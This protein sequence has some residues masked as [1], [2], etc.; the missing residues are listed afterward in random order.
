MGGVVAGVI[1]PGGGSLRVT[2]LSVPGDNGGGIA[3][4]SLYLLFIF[5]VYLQKAFPGELRDDPCLF[6]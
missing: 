3:G 1:D 6:S 5:L 2:G 4:L